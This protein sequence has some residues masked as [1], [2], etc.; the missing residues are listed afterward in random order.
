M[1]HLHPY[2]PC[3]LCGKKAVWSYM[4]SNWSYCEDCVPRGCSCTRNYCD[5]Q[6]KLDE[7]YE[8]PPTDPNHKWKW[9]EENGIW[10]SLDEQGREY[11]CC[12][13]WKIHEDDHNDKE[14]LDIGWESYYK[15]H[16][17]ERPSDISIP[18][19]FHKLLDS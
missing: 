6:S 11:P 9:L 7:L 1:I 8:S 15:E 12:E 16:E 3:C 19:K 13:Y 10:V 2:I 17:A 18:A 14:F 4:P 5:E